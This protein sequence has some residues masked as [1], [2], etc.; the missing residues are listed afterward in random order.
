MARILTM[1]VLIMIRS[2]FE[3]THEG[4]KSP[5]SENNPG[6]E[7]VGSASVALLPADSSRQ[8]LRSPLPRC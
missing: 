7:S 6:V 5:V 4:D 3:E 8:A 2:I 1:Q